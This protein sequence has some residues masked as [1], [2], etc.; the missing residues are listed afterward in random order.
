[1]AISTFGGTTS[2][3]YQ[4]ISS[5]TP[6]AGATAVN[7]TGLA[8]YKKLL[9]WNSGIVLGTAGTVTVRLNN[10]SNN[11]NYSWALRSRNNSATPAEVDGGT[12]SFRI[13]ASA[14]TTLNTEGW[15]AFRNCD[16]TG[17]KFVEGAVNEADSAASNWYTQ[18]AY[19]GTAVISQVS[20]LV[21]TT[22]TAVG[23]VS[24]YGVR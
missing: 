17:I 10:D 16:V 6:T 12:S 5:V 11:T 23:T 18:G 1:M 4:L 20:L 2:D 3:N 24:L 7:F 9:L 19:R 8:V 15:I 13:N 21:N 22:F 14:N